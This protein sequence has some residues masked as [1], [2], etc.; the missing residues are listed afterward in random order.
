MK[1][2]VI[3][4]A[5][6]GMVTGGK[7]IAQ[8]SSQLK[9][10]GIFLGATNYLGEL[11]GAS[12]IGR[13]F[14]NDLELNMTRPA[15]G[16]FYRY[17]LNSFLSVRGNFIWGVARGND[18][19]SYPR[20]VYA[21]EWYRYYRNL[22]V[23]TSITEFSAQ[24]ELNIM[25]YEPRRKRYRF[26]PYFFV[27]VGG[28]QFVP[29]AKY[30]DPNTGSER[31]VDLRSLGTEGQGTA[32]YPDRQKYRPI[33]MC[34]PMGFGFKYAINRYWNLGFEFGHR[35]TTTDY[36]DDV[37]KTYVGEEI[38]N[39]NFDEET[40]ALMYAMSRRS[41]E[42]TGGANYSYVTD[43]YQQRGDPHD[44]DHYM[45]MGAMVVIFNITGG[46]IITPKF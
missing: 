17:N 27:G 18:A 33:A 3:Y 2:I 20:A 39:N 40:A 11:G 36:L 12:K 7:L 32:E 10:I 38:F 19:L 41:Q 8:A 4:I 14:I 13:P 44:F 37:S 31:W 16:M 26:A 22:S 28:F 35:I 15:V 29:K 21:D 9:E 30:L 6:L 42:I 23:K 43:T 1:R 25:K 45:F 46:K 24:F 5:I 34:F